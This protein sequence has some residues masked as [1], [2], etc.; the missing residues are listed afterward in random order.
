MIALILLG[1]ASI[2][3]VETKQPNTLPLVAPKKALIWV[4]FEVCLTHI[5]EGLRQVG[6][7]R[8]FLVGCNYDV[9]DIGQYIPAY[10]VLQ[11][12]LRH[13]IESGA[14]IAQTLRH[15][16]IVICAKRSYE[17]GLLFILLANPYLV[18]T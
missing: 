4:E 6:D 8:L 2:A 14:C 1:L 9:I 3:L 16:H 18:I 7:V 10:L 15:S 12:C 5:G 11:C 17:T 13:S